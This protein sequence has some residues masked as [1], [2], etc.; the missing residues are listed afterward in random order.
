M[1]P[2]TTPFRFFLDPSRPNMRLRYTRPVRRREHPNLP[3]LIHP[4]YGDPTIRSP[5]VTTEM[6]CLKQV[7]QPHR[8]PL[9]GVSQGC[10]NLSVCVRVP[11]GN[12]RLSTQA[13]SDIN[14]KG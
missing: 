4:E 13:Q 5:L 10:V 2:P 11:K 14:L 6:T 8:P 1:V 9:F 12:R 3:T 7:L